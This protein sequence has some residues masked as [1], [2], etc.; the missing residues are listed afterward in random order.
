M[1]RLPSLFLRVLSLR[2]SPLQTLHLRML[3][4]QKLLLRILPLQKLLLLQSPA[5]LLLT[6]SG[7]PEPAHSLLH[8]PEALQSAVPP[9]LLQLF[10]Q[11]L[12]SALLRCFL[13]DPQKLFPPELQMQQPSFCGVC[14]NRLQKPSHLS[15][16]RLHR[17]VMLR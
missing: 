4:L 14:K 11:L 2:M 12:F 7:V 16:Q 6:H 17:L 5:L 9:V 13:Q 3:S 1:F 10:H 8:L 15:W